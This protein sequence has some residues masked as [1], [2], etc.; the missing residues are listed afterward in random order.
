MFIIP[1]TAREPNEQVK[2]S[3]GLGTVQNEQPNKR[4]CSVHPPFR[5]VNTEQAGRTRD[6]TGRIRVRGLRVTVLW[7]NGEN[8]YLLPYDGSPRLLHRTAI[9]RDE[10]FQDLA[11]TNPCSVTVLPGTSYFGTTRGTDMLIGNCPIAILA[12]EQSIPD[13]FTVKTAGSYL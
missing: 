8:V 2:V 10:L 9:L 12:L 13:H 5:G 4:Q 3:A 11:S 1:F 7:V 6:N